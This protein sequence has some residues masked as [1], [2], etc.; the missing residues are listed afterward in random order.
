LKYFKIISWILVIGWMIV[1]FSLS[2]NVGEES[3]NKSRRVVENIVEVVEKN[4]TKQEKI[5]IVNKIHNP[6][7]K[8]AHAFEYCILCIL[9]I[10][11]LKTNG[12]KNKWIYLLAV[13]LSFIYSLTDEYHQTL[14]SGRSGEIRDCFIDLLGAIIG[15]LLC[16]FTILIKKT[17]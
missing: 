11:A 1:I 6:F 12:V 5:K 17:N 4:K 8:F 9:I 14:V 16:R 3:S 15:Y 10:I 2:S 7:R 13:L